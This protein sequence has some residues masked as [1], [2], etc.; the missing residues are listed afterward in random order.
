M[1]INR[2]KQASIW[3]YLLSAALFVSGCSSSDTN[4]AVNQNQSPTTVAVEPPIFEP[5]Q[6][7]VP[8][9]PLQVLPVKV[10]D[11]VYLRLTI[12][13][14]L[15]PLKTSRLIE[16]SLDEGATWSEI[17]GEQENYLRSGQEA[18]Q[19]KNI[20][21]AKQHLF[22]ISL[23]NATGEKIYSSATPAI[24]SCEAPSGVIADLRE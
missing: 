7:P 3:I 14:D 18:M 4:Q 5:P 12:A 23:T 9:D 10:K 11:T 19:V 8:V 16:M 13:E 21:E 20:P 24:S 2:V 17:S 1:M 6:E 22:R 15:L